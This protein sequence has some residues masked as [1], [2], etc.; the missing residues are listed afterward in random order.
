MQLFFRLMPQQAFDDKANNGLVPSGNKPLC[1]SFFTQIFVIWATTSC[2]SYLSVVVHNW[3]IISPGTSSQG[4]ILWGNYHFNDAAP[5]GAKRVSLSSKG[6]TPCSHICIISLSS[7]H[8]NST[9]I[10]HHQTLGRHNK[11]RKFTKHSNA[12]YIYILWGFLPVL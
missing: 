10:L 2:L 11:S 5:D 4:R 6:N 3:Y 12:L 7:I 1:E 9:I 8:I